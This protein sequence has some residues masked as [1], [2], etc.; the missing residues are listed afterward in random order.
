MC[1]VW[2][3]AF[4]GL[5]LLALAGEGWASAVVSPTLREDDQFCL[6]CHGEGSHSKGA[7][8]VDGAALEQS[9]HGNLSCSDCHTG[10]IAIPHRASLPQADCTRCHA[11]EGEAALKAQAG[12]E[13]LLDQHS[14]VR[15]RGAT[16]LPTCVDCHGA[17]ELRR[18]SG[19]TAQVG[20]EEIVETC[21]TCHQVIAADYAG[22]VHGT[23]ARMGN[24]DVPTCEDCHPEH[25]RL[26]RSSVRE[27]GVVATCVSC[28]DDPGLQAKYA[29][30]GGRLASYLGSYH[31]AATELG[32]SRTADCASCHGVHD[33]L[34]SD[35]FRS[36][37][38][39]ANLRKTCG[40]CHP[41]AG[42]H[43]AEGNIHLQPT[44]TQDR[45]VFFVRTGY[46]LFIVGL[47][48]S[49]I[50]YIGLDLTARV[51]KR[52]GPGRPSRGDLGPEPEFER[53]TLNQRIQHWLLIVSF[54]TLLVS[55]LPLTS[56][57]SA[58]SRGV[59]TFLGGMGARAVIHRAAAIGLVAICC[60]HL[61][62]VLFSRRGHWEFRQL[63]PGVQDAKD[64]LQMLKFYFGLTPVGARFGRYNFIE[65]FEYLSV[66]WGSVIMIGTGVL[67][68]APHLSLMFFPKW[69]M[70]VAFAL[71]SWEAILAFLA[72]IVWHMYNVHLN[73]PV[74]PMSRV[75]LT[76]KIG[77]HELRENHPL[78]YERLVR[79]QNAP[80]REEEDGP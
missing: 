28:H 20:Q 26:G 63:I 21:S 4:C 11:V 62:Y 6:G 27:R 12:D 64:V 68:W 31:G 8:I 57:T 58:I 76:G 7:A 48:S 29:I 46:L 10:V 39:R 24:P 5:W 44:F 17:H 22:S 71:H 80:A 54:T 33:V 14:E 42:E 41:G 69:L 51:R 9:A 45:I 35:D 15:H 13:A 61:L 70:D 1:G 19:P 37:V 52:F 18:P 78:E 73:P 43:F 50:G 72:I 66:G 38:N 47:M 75:W 30:P 40:G 34:P 56:P 55:G 16:G 65:K 36:R 32:D 79:Q 23:A 49:F 74:F 60:Y 77:L 53:L 2:M 59:I 67:L 3:G 25:A